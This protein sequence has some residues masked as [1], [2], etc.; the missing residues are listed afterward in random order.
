MAIAASIGLIPWTFVQRFLIS[1]LDL[2]INAETTV[3][4][5]QFTYCNNEH[6]QAGHSDLAPRKGIS[7]HNVLGLLLPHAPEQITEHKT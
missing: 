6:P 3:S 4:G 2:R 5:G 1:G 7:G